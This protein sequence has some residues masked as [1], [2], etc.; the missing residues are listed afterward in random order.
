MVWAG[1]KGKPTNIT[2]VIGVVGQQNIEG[3]RIRFGFNRRTLPH[4][5][6]DDNGPESRGFVK[7]NYFKGLKPGEFFFHT[8]GGREGLSDTAVKTSKTGYL[9]RKLVKAL[10]DVISRY[11]GTV[12][13]S[14]GNI[15]QTSY[16]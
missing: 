8:M 12:R 16:G 5:Q 15:I 2:Q 4:F 10:E 6:K 7:T 14:L 9:Q 1:S 11:D 3:A 13:D